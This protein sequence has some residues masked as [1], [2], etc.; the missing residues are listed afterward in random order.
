MQFIEE[1]ISRLSTIIWS[2]FLP[3]L[4]ITAIVISF[5]FFTSV[6]NKTSKP[7]KLNPRDIIGPAAISMGAMIGTGAVI[8]VLGSM[9][10][11]VTNGQNYFE[12]IAGWS[13]IGAFILIPICYIET[14]VC[15]ITKL[16]PKRYISKFI[17]PLTG[18]IYAYAFILLYVFGFGGFQV[19]GINSAIT[20]LVEGIFGISA[21]PMA[22]YVEIVL[23]LLIIV[24]I[25]VLAKK[26]EVFINSMA[27]MI[28][29]AVLMY[30]VMVIIFVTKTS[31]Y[32]PTYI[33]NIL[34]GMKN[35]VTAGIGLPIGFT[36]AV[37]RI[38]QT[39]EPGLG[40]LAMSSLDSDSEP[41]AAGLISLIPSVTTVFLAIFVTSYI[42]SYGVYAGVMDLG[43][44]D[45]LEA[46]RGYF[47]ISFDVVGWYGLVTI[48]VFTILS[49]ITSLLGS[50]YFLSVL[51][52]FSENKNIAIYIFLIFAAGTLAIFGGSFIFEAVDLL[53]FVV[54]GTNLAAILL[55]VFKYYKDYKID[56]EV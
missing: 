25:I 9:M 5:R 35:P 3:I 26:H 55:F 10:N 29:A 20:I 28:G 17:T 40:A 6:K 2:I 56:S 13:L 53:M 44:A 37:Q 27:F 42:T 43:N 16:T 50:Y 15:K 11:L 41:R 18:T 51:L 33:N 14:L 47:L 34:L 38:T 24:S 8:G 12:A 4:I 36:V 45:A 49:G 46:L 54:T 52:D 39:S 7:S 22:R 32:V 30:L 48:T 31:D 19:Q 21:S 1:I 23:P